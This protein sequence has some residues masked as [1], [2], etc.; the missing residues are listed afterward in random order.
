MQTSFLRR[1]R[2]QETQ[3]QPSGGIMPC[4]TAW[5]PWR[6]RQ[7]MLFCLICISLGLQH[8]MICGQLVHA[9]KI[10]PFFPSP[11][12][13][14][15]PSLGPLP[16]CKALSPFPPS[17]FP[18]SH[19]SPP[20]TSLPMWKRS[21]YFLVPTYYFYPNHYLWRAHIGKVRPSLQRVQISKISKC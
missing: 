6:L 2:P 9:H 15:L 4:P 17:P 8:V 3:Q 20:L 13:L 16:L 7:S 11:T 14:L 21:P 5:L 18:P 19:L 12:L 10:S 1:E